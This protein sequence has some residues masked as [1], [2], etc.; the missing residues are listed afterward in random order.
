MKYLKRLI[1]LGGLLLAGCSTFTTEFVDADGTNFRSRT[2]IAPFSKMDQD[3]AQMSYKWN[4]TDGAIGIGRDIQ[5]VDQTAQLEAAKV[6]MEAVIKA[7]QAYLAASTGIP[8]ITIPIPKKP[9][10]PIV[11]DIPPPP[12]EPAE[13]RNE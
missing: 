7:A 9:E 10:A 11:L 8:P 3:V 12:M 5:G 2:M 6:A 4:Q 1:A 13:V